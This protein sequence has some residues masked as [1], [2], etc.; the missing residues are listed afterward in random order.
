MQKINKNNRTEDPSGTVFYKSITADN[1]NEN[2]PHYDNWGLETLKVQSA[3]N[4]ID[5][6]TTVKVGVFDVGFSKHKD[7]NYYAMENNPETTSP[8][9]NDYGFEVQIINTF[10]GTHVSGIIAAN[11]NDDYGIMGVANDVQLYAYSC[12]SDGA[13]SFIEGKKALAYLIGNRV[14]VINISLGFEPVISYA[15]TR[16]NKNAIWN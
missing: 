4:K 12:G 6:S 3:W 16:E 15:A 1:W 8:Y 9:V 2:S 7:I 10:H 14:K 5:K 11:H 13:V